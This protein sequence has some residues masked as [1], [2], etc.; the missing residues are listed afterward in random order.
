LKNYRKLL[1]EGNYKIGVWGI[2][3]IGFSSMLF[4]AR[5]G[6]RSVGYDKIHD[7]LSRIASGE[8]LLEELN[9]WLGFSINPII[10]SGLIESTDNYKRLL[11]DDI[12][13]HL[14]AIPTEKD[15][16][17]FLDILYD[18]I[19]KICEMSNKKG[20]KPLIIIES[21]LTPRTSENKILPKFKEKGFIPGDDFLYGVSPRRDWFVSGGKNLEE[22][23][24]VYGG[25]DDDS[26][27]AMNDVL[28][29]VCQKLHRA[30][31]HQVSEMVKSFENAYRHMEITLANEFSLAY[32]KENVREILKLVGT[33]WNIGT[34]RPGFGTG[35][36]CI[37]LSSKYAIQG[38]EKP[39][40]LGILKSTINTDTKINH[41][42]AKSIIKT[43]YKKVG[44]LGLSYKCNLKVHILSPTI[45]FVADLVKAGI[46][47]KVNDPLFLEHEIRDIVGAD[48]FVFPDQLDQFEVIVLVVDHTE[49]KETDITDRLDNCKYVLD[50]V[51]LWSDIFKDNQD[52]EYHLC[53]DNGWLQ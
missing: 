52:I 49:Y 26:A 18:V 42:I 2:G 46:D 31:N 7:K 4:C 16:E 47:V 22:L 53:G 27:C 11:E 12:L 23:D 32:P 30:S 50:N 17:P 45:P 39:N 3:Y 19:D 38:A 1:L 13:V 51:G 20:P 8:Y 41:L 5:K 36:Y 28:G 25:F 33:K 14:V 44:V 6:I 35:G 10:E 34:Y 37:P 21:T 29:I 15:G 43:G 48:S 24:R 9:E 40:E